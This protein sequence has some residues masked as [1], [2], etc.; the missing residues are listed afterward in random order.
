V[1]FTLNGNGAITG[2]IWIQESGILEGPIA[3]TS[4]YSVSVVRDA[5]LQWQVARP[6]LQPLGLPVVAETNDG[7]VNDVNGF[8]VKAEHVISALENVGTYPDIN[9]ENQSRYVA[10][11]RD[12]PLE[13]AVAEAM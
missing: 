9:M 1:W 12:Q 2:T 7:R 6:G 11:E 10:A 4:T 5:I 8:Y 3:I 13:R